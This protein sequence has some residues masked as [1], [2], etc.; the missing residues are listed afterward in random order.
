MIKCEIRRLALIGYGDGFTHWH[1]NGT[2]T[3]IN[4][5]KTDGFFNPVA[6]MLATGNMITAHDAT[7]AGVVLWVLADR[8]D[9]IIR[10]AENG[11]YVTR[12]EG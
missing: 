9:G 10:T 7:G 3:T 8:T 1:Y 12:G 2:A 4:A 6:D 11:S 5:I